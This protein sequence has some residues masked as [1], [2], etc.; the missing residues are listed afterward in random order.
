M[1]SDQLPLLDST[2]PISQSQ[3]ET[4]RQ[5]GHLM[6]PNLLSSHELQACR[7][8]IKEATYRHNTEFRQMEERD[9][10]G[11]AFLQVM[12]LWAKNDQVKR[13]TLAKRFGKMAAELL[14]VE[15]VR[16]YHDQAL[17][18]EP[19]G[20]KTPWHQDQYYWPLD[21]D[22]TI[23]MWMPLVDITEDL[24]M[25]TF[26]SKSHQNGFAGNIPISDASEDFFERIIL[27]NGYKISR[28][29]EMKAGD[30]TW[31]YG[32]TI[33]SA[34]ANHSEEFTREVMTI[35]Y[36]ADGARVTSSENNDQETDRSRWLDNLSEGELAASKLNPLVL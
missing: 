3:V 34:P 33:H 18:K 14:G 8:V 25:L 12:N 17:Y 4:F 24:G 13:F 7:A 20:G 27:E 32:W 21:T 1:V 11:K 2:K 10:Y 23:T 19:G 15:N 30:A 22:K 9:T 36:F 16:I 35:I 6:T 28:L 26:A 29:K 5:K 31:H